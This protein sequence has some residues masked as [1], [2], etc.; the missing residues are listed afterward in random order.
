V[1]REAAI[2]AA[3]AAGTLDP[4][5]QLT[6]TR[7]RMGLVDGWDIRPGASVLEIGCGQ[8]DM[9]AVLADAVGEQG[10]VVGVDSAEPLPSPR[11]CQPHPSW[12][13]R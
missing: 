8:G 13:P 6:Q 12:Q 11:A 1:T 3:M 9:T 4:A 10:R 7:Y 2:V 5:V